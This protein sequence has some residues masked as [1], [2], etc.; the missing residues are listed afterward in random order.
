VKHNQYIR[1]GGVFL[2]TLVA[3]GFALAE[4]DTGILAV[5]R[6]IV[7]LPLVFFLPGFALM[8][9]FFPPRTLNPTARVMFSIGLSMALTL[10]GGFVLHQTSGGLNRTHWAVL[11]GGLT[12]AF[13]IGVFTRQVLFRPDRVPVEDTGAG[14]DLSLHQIALFALTAVIVVSA[15]YLA[16]QSEANRDEPGF[17][18]LWAVRAE[19]NP[20]LVDLGIRNMEGG[21][22]RFRLQVRHGG[23]LI[24]NRPLIVLEDGHTWQTTLRLSP[25]RTG[26]IEALLYRLDQP[27]QVYRRVLLN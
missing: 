9:L 11:L 19:D 16:R 14:L 1:L 22:M 25:A 2:A 4:P 20:L 26:P 24:D 27:D 23:Q 6:V 21:P 3:M 18:Q 13:E 17:T 12:L 10:L 8:E 15:I 7:V 5:I